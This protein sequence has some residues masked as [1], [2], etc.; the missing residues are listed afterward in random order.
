MTKQLI[1]S[2]DFQ[3]TAILIKLRNLVSSTVVESGV[4]TVGEVPSGV[5]SDANMI[6]L[7]EIFPSG[8]VISVPTYTC[9]VGHTLEIDLTVTHL[10]KRPFEARLFGKVKEVEKT[11]NE[12]ER[13]SIELKNAS[14]VPWK[15]FCRLFEQR[16][17]S[18][19]KFIKDVRGY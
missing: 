6:Q 13:I 5:A 18:I 7:L 9:A 8:L 4:K 11:S 3:T 12:Q 2:D 15:D 19:H 14:D 1:N 10:T 17:E 16:Q